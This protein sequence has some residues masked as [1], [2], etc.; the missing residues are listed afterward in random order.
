MFNLLHKNNWLTGALIFLMPVTLIFF[1]GSQMAYGQVKN[2]FERYQDIPQV[3]TLSELRAIPAGQVVMLRGLMAESPPRQ[4]ATATTPDLTVFQVRP[5][6]GREVHFQEEFP[7][8]FPEFGLELTDGPVTIV[9]SSTRERV[10]QHE[11]HRLGDEEYE[12][13]GFR[14]GDR[15]MVQGQWQPDGSPALIEATGISG[16]DKASLMVEWQRAFQKVSW[17]RNILAA[18]TVAGLSLLLGQLRRGRGNYS[19]QELPVGRGA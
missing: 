6:T 13:T 11:L 7:L 18:L 1:L 8:I 9:P 15:V 3:S 5:A 16:G 12:Y 14:P 17:A 10:I 2:Q 19:P 4:G